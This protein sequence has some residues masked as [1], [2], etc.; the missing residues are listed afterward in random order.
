MKC[1]EQ[2]PSATWVIFRELS[3]IK[4]SMRD[5]AATTAGDFDLLQKMAAFFKQGNRAIGSHFSKLQCGEKTRSAATNHGEIKNGRMMI[6]KRK[7]K[8]VSPRAKQPSRVCDE[9]STCQEI[10]DSLESGSLL[11][12]SVEQPAAR[13]ASNTQS[14]IVPQTAGCLGK[15]RQQATAV[16]GGVWP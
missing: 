8:K 2:F 11:P 15:K 7:R 9:P 10:T 6:Q 3:R 4:T 5:I 16:H 1:R 12:L 14:R 13:R